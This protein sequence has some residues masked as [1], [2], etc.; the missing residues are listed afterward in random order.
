MRGNFHAP[1]LRGVRHSNVSCLPGV[2]SGKV[3]GIDSLSKDYTGSDSLL[4]VDALQWSWLPPVGEMS[5]NNFALPSRIWRQL[6]RSL[7]TINRIRYNQKES[8][9]QHSETP[10]S[11]PAP[12]APVVKEEHPMAHATVG[13]ITIIYH[14]RAPEPKGQGARRLSQAGSLWAPCCGVQLR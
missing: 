13:R 6:S 5:W 7:S 3:D 8:Y 11:A 9:C 2:T 10:R 4:G 14:G 12:A 1:Y